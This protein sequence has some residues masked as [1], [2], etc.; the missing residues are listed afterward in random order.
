[1]VR[2][3]LIIVGVG[4]GVHLWRKVFHNALD[5]VFNRV[6]L[7]GVAMPDGDEVRVEADRKSNTTELVLYRKQ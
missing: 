1:M 5:D 2:V 6:L 3:S 4:L 7:G